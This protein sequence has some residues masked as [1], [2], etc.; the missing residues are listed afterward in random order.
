MATTV[1]EG[2]KFFQENLKRSMTGSL[3]WSFMKLDGSFQGRCLDKIKRLHR[4]IE[5]KTQG[6]DISPLAFHQ[7]SYK[8]IFSMPLD[9]LSKFQCSGHIWSLWK[10][11][12]NILYK[13]ILSLHKYNWNKPNKKTCIQICD[14]EIGSCDLHF[15]IKH[16]D[17]SLTQ[18]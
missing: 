11:F 15:A 4:W 12:M 3:L 13:S 2:I 17:V 8:W 7:C 1:C 18:L 5:D 6:H 10:F 9:L 16:F 14:C